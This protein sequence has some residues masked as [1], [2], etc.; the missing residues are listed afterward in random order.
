MNDTLCYSTYKTNPKHTI[1]H[2]FHEN[3]CLDLCHKICRF[4][5]WNL[6]WLEASAIVCPPESI[7]NGEKEVW[8]YGGGSQWRWWMLL[9]ITSRSSVKCS[10]AVCMLYMLHHDPVHDSLCISKESHDGGKETFLNIVKLKMGWS[11]SPWLLFKLG[12][13][14]W[15]C[16]APEISNQTLWRCV[17]NS[18][19][20]I[21]LLNSTV[22]RVQDTATCLNFTTYFNRWLRT[23]DS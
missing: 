1:S 9:A 2:N 15:R 10:V 8:W 6:G 4:L 14:Y 21:R 19:M 23:L 16:I 17:H 11:N 3:N 7:A 12:N 20:I 22:T 13:S 18:S 5:F